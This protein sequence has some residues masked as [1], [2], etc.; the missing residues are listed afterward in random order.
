MTHAAMPSLRKHVLLVDDEPM[1]QQ[2]VD[3]ALRRDVPGTHV[4]CVDSG[5]EA[6]QV[7]ARAPVD[8]LITS[9][10]MP[11]IDGVELL[12]HVVNRR[13]A[14]PVL[15]MGGQTDDADHL[16]SSALEILAEPI[17][18]DRLIRRARELLTAPAGAP[19]PVLGLRE[20][21]RMVGL[22]RRTC[23]LRAVHEDIHGVLYFTGGALVDART[24]DLHGEPAALAVLAWNNP[25]TNFDLLLRARPVTI[26]AGIDELLHRAAQAARV[27]LRVAPVL[28][29]PETTTSAASVEA[30]PAAELVAPDTV[31]TTSAAAAE[32]VETAPVADPVELSAADLAETIPAAEALVTDPAAEPALLTNAPGDAEPAPVTIVAAAAPAADPAAPSEP[33]PWERPA[34]AA[35]ISRVLTEVLTIDGALGA[36]MAVWELGHTLG[37]RGD[38]GPH[39]LETAVVGNCR[40]MRAVL[41]TLN[42]LDLRG[43]VHDVLITLDDQLHILT[44]LPRHGDLFLYVAIDR[45]LGSLALTRHRVQRL[46][47]DLRL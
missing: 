45:E 43:G 29:D 39:A 2:I 35:T 28:L 8:L 26:A 20:L 24:G 42:R 38:L 27:P 25:V 10:V 15:M 34:A 16:A 36:A 22:A 46:L 47:A 40:V 9:L 1:T 21:V 11:V 17:E 6:L 18:I 31:E 23:A 5:G 13:L 30:T 32:P 3:R 14:M 37:T 7:L 4:T 12:R 41:T 33:A 19:E 44:P